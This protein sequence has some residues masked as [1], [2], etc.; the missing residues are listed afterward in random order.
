M[1]TKLT[2]LLRALHP[3]SLWL[4]AMASGTS[5]LRA[6]A[7]AYGIPSLQLQAT[8]L[9]RAVA[10]AQEPALA[11]CSTGEALERASD[12]L[13]ASAEA[14]MS[15]ACELSRVEEAVATAQRTQ[16]EEVRERVQLKLQEQGL[17]NSP[18]AEAI[19][20]AFEVQHV[21]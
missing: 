8:E 9:Q 19:L 3:F 13:L 7:K 10:E 16:I 21:Q 2:R 12:A 1:T 17:A 18:T 6:E 15:V 14:V 5:P 20:T 11:G 4:D